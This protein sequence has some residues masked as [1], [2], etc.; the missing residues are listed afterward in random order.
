MAKITRWIFARNESEANKQVNQIKDEYCSVKSGTCK[1][2]FDDSGEWQ[3][4]DKIGFWLDDGKCFDLWSLSNKLPFVYK[5]TMDLEALENLKQRAIDTTAGYEFYLSFPRDILRG[6]M[7][8]NSNLGVRLGQR[9]I[10]RSFSDPMFR[11]GE[12]KRIHSDAEMWVRLYNVLFDNKFIKLLTGIS[13]VAEPDYDKI[14]ALSVYGCNVTINMRD[15]ANGLHDGYL[16]VNKCQGIVEVFEV[17]DGATAVLV[18]GK[19]TLACN[20]VKYLQNGVLSFTTINTRNP[21]FYKFV[22]DEYFIEL[23]PINLKHGDK[24]AIIKSVQQV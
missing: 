8:H 4:Q 6:F 24:F 5:F 20:D 9:Y 15:I 22:D 16:D 21:G 10:A 17:L 23:V 18:D 2:R 14:V 3:I 1:I 13:E 11:N 12:F 7:T 19:F